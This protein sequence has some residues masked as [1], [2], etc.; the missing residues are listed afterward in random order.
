MYQVDGILAFGGNITWGNPYLSTLKAGSLSV[1]SADLG[2][3]GISNTGSLSTNSKTYGS[4]SGVFI[5]YSGSAY[6]FDVGSANSYL[7]FDGTTVIATGLAIKSPNG[8][9][10]FATGDGLSFAA[11]FPNT[12]N[13]PA[14]NATVGAVLGSNLKDADSTTV[15]TSNDIKNSAL[16]SVISAAQQAAEDAHALASS[17]VSSR[18]STS[19]YLSGYSVWSN[20]AANTYFTTAPFF[21]PIINDRLTQYDGLGFSETRVWDGNAW[22]KVSG[23][24]DGSLVVVGT[25]TSDALST[26]L[27]TVGQRIESVD[28]NFVID[29]ANKFISVSV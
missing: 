20:A 21:S 9:S 16:T 27:V 22:I 4:G 3:V 19:A 1:L 5:G 26:N 12:T 17:V 18:G 29:L 28:K 23:I 13:M 7:R 11:R 15:L 25:V 14:E 24:F 6:K 2:T 10:I 8:N